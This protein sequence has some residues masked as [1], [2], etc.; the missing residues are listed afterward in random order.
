MNNNLA[1]IPEIWAMEA[2]LFLTQRK[3]AVGFVNRQFKDEV[4]S[5]GETVHCHRVETRKVRRKGG[6]DEYVD[7]DANTEDVLVKLD[8][9]LY[10]S[11]TIYDDEQSLAQTDLI[12]LHLMPMID[13][14]ATGIDRAILGRCVEFLQQGSPEKRA[15]KLAGMTKD[16]SYEFLLESQEILS[17]NK[18]PSGVRAGFF[19]PTAITKLLLNP[20]FVRANERG[21]GGTALETGVVGTLANINVM[22]GQNANYKSALYADTQ[23]ST[24]TEVRAAGFAGIHAIT[25]PGTSPVVGEFFV[26]EENGQPTYITDVD[27]DTAITLNEPLKY[28]LTDNGLATHYLKATNEAT[29]RAAG[30]Q[31]EL[32]LTHTSGKPVS[33]GQMLAF[34]TTTRHVYTV[35]EATVVD[36][37]HVS[38]LLDRPLD[39]AVGSGEVC[40]PGP[41][42]TINPVF[43]QDAIAFVSRP[44]IQPQTGAGAYSSVVSYGGMTIRVT[45]QY[46]ATKG[47]HKV[48]VDMLG[49]VAVLNDKLLVPVLG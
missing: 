1:L 22:E 33:T 42:G 30:Y 29:A 45:I 13:T 49:G 39:V 28:A 43:H 2:L 18:A 12:R 36:A 8:Q 27:S 14:I 21:D 3:S 46:N 41:I 15:G 35:I 38:V 17:M 32:V 34:G 5:Y 4:R 26:F 40:F 11:T 31:K 20:L 6:K 25:D 9:L 44:L 23:A 24:T 48:N 19:H 37:T 47:G 10:D 16:N 7:N